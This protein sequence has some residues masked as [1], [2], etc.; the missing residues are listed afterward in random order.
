MCDPET[1]KSKGFGF[2]SFDTFEASDTS[3]AAMNGQYICGSQIHVQYAFKK[4]GSQ[5]ERHGSAAERLLAASSAQFGVKPHT[6]FSADNGSTTSSVPQLPVP[7]VGGVIPPLPFTSGIPQMGIP[8][9]PIGYPQYFVPPPL[10]QYF[11]TPQMP[12]IPPQS[13]PIYFFV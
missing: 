10:P 7:L 4:D 8:P 6:K 5:G 2:I 11:P 3:I 13:M 9:I 1:G 12:L